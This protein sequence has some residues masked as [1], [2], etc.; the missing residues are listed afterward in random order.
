MAQAALS[1]IRGPNLAP[2]QQDV[3]DLLEASEREVGGGNITQAEI[4]VDRAASILTAE[5]LKSQN[6]EPEFFQLVVSG[7]DRVWNQRPDNDSLFKHVTEARIDLATLRV[8]QKPE[9]AANEVPTGPKQAEPDL[10][11]AAHSGAAA[12]AAV[13]HPTD[14]LLEKNEESRSATARIKHLPIGAPREIAANSTVSPETL[15]ANYLDATADARY[16]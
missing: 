13:G 16:G 8:A 12:G 15:G 11:P 10:I 7:L 9:P 14:G 3:M 5:R 1:V 4:S 6:S 2:W